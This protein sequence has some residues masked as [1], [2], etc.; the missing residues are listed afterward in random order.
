MRVRERQ[1]LQVPRL[2]GSNSQLQRLL[3]TFSRDIGYSDSPAA[4][5]ASSQSGVH[6]NADDAPFPQLPHTA[7]R[8]DVTRIAERPAHANTAQ[9]DDE[10]A[11]RQQLVHFVAELVEELGQTANQP[12]ELR[13]PAIGPGQPCG[14]V[15]DQLDVGI[16]QLP[17]RLTRLI[18]M[19]T[20]LLT[21]ST[22]SCDIAYSDS[23]AASRASSRSR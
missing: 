17:E 6:P 23:P 9:A 1:C 14:R 10:I 8:L 5:R 18:P 21:K 22:F 7:A 13:A 11:S 15:K 3:S 12:V 20:D 2:S 19:V 4:S 16:E